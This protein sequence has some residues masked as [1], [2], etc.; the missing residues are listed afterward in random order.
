M[1]ICREA[2]RECRRKKKEYVKCLEN[3]V[4]V[5][6]NQNKTLIEELKALKE[7]Y[8]QKE[9]W[10]DLITDLLHVNHKEESQILWRC[11]QRTA[12]QYVFWGEQS[13]LT[14]MFHAHLEAAVRQGLDVVY[15][16]MYSACA[17]IKWQLVSFCSVVCFVKDLDVMLRRKKSSTVLYVNQAVVVD[18]IALWNRP[19]PFPLPWRWQAHNTVVVYFC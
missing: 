13:G 8:C 19:V 4:A 10:S 6:E 3:R 12:T 5:L 15:S 14:C 7:L 2:A 18:V 17:F 16:S 1:F 9:G 11:V